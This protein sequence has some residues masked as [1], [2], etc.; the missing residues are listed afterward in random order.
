MFDVEGWFGYTNWRYFNVPN[1]TEYPE[2]LFIRKGKSIR[3]NKAGN[4]TDRHYQIEPKNPMTLDAYK[5]ALDNFARNA[6]VR[7]VELS[8][9]K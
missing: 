4:R 9:V 1:N 7:Q 6:V 2:S 5:G 8:R 3:T